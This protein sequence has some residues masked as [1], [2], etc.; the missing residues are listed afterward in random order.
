MRQ[1]VHHDN[2]ARQRAYR[3]RKR[4]A[5]ARS[6]TEA[7]AQDEE[8]EDC[9]SFPTLDEL[10]DSGANSEEIAGVIRCYFTPEQC[11]WIAMELLRQPGVFDAPIPASRMEYGFYDPEISNEAAARAG[12]IDDESARELWLMLNT[13]RINYRREGD[14]IK[15]WYSRRY[16]EGHSPNDNL[17]PLPGRVTF[18]EA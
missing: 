5:T 1:R 10:S 3:E 12:E 4:N 9:V 14:S 13:R 7:G 8:Q 6:V 15:R 16:F 11:K 17:P 2:A 18:D